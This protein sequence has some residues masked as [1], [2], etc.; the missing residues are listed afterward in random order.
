MK[1][2]NY[3]EVAAL[4]RA[5]KQKLEGAQLQAVWSYDQGLVLELYKFESYWLV[6]DVSMTLP[7]VGLFEKAPSFAKKPKPVALYIHA[8]LKN[9]RL[10]DVDLKLPKERILILTFAGGPK[11]GEIQ[12]DLIP[13]AANL[14]VRALQKEIFWDKP[15]P[16]KEPSGFELPD[17]E[18][19]WDPIG[20]SLEWLQFKTSLG[21][22]ERGPAMDSR[23]KK[24]LKLQKALSEIKQRLDQDQAEEFFKLGEALK[25]GQQLTEAQKKLLEPKL[26]L[27]DNQEK[28]F[29]KAKEL[30]QKKEGSLS[31]LGLLKIEIENIEKDIQENP[32]PKNEATVK[33][34][35]TGLEKAQVRGR[36]KQI[37]E[38]LT[39]AL[40]RSAEENLQ[41]LRKSQAWDLWIHLKDF[42]S[43]YGILTRTR[44]RQVNREELIEAAKWLIKE[45]VAKKQ[46][47]KNEKLSVVFAE[48]RHVRPIKG[49]KIGRVTYQNAQ[50]LVI[51]I[52][53]E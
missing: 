17:Q 3:L 51:A 37:A 36:K 14:S 39:M 38:D 10:M 19:Q 32:I 34:N 18:I 42:P 31:R 52:G 49:D 46:S 28:A 43:S 9:L 50:Q 23:L 47:L 29:Q 1:A 2:L 53:D 35:V 41:L 45:T 40:G 7:F 27:R 5:L 20:K 44:N 4:G 48:C 30:R 15:K 6:L 16:E 11:E 12:I 24:L 26:S 13:R 25:W 22:T 33:N 21:K 8:H